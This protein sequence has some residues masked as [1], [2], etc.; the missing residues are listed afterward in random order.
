MNPYVSSNTNL[1]E[2]MGERESAGGI[3][4]LVTNLTA[5]CSTKTGDSI[6]CLIT[7]T[8]EFTTYIDADIPD[9]VPLV[10]SLNTDWVTPLWNNNGESNEPV[11]DWFFIIWFDSTFK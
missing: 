6:V 7:S 9:S 11:V 4:T 2:T 8:K 3:V 5:S 10:K 1:P